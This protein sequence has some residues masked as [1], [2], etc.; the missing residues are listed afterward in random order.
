M[1][2]CSQLK[3]SRER[4]EAPVPNEIDI[5]IAISREKGGGKHNRARG[6]R[7]FKKRIWML[8]TTLCK[9]IEA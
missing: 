6:V 5:A 7:V 4:G 2:K 1:N 3:H 8:A 9:N